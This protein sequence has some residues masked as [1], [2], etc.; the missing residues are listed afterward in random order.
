MLIDEE[1]DSLNIMLSASYDRIDSLKELS[2]LVAEVLSSLSIESNFMGEVN[3]EQFRETFT[4]EISGRID[5]CL[6]R[7]SACNIEQKF[8][9]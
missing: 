5:D 8:R 1:L 7:L 9:L 2:G 3:A 4:G 6:G